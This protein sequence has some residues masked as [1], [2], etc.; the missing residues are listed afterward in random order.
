MNSNQHSKTSNSATVHR[1]Y[2]SCPQ[3]WKLCRNC[4]MSDFPFRKQRWSWACSECGHLGNV[5]HYC[6]TVGKNVGGFHSEC[7]KCHEH[8]VWCFYKPSACPKRQKWNCCQCG[9][10]IDD[11]LNCVD[12]SCGGCG[13][14]VHYCPKAAAITYGDS[15]NCPHCSRTPGVPNPQ[16]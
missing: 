3:H 14:H 2:I 8:T 4:G 12:V 1:C 6:Q 13:N 16:G 15:S 10:S 9:S 11:R 5:K 7:K